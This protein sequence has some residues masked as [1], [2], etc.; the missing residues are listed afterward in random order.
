MRSSSLLL[1][2]LALT[3]AVSCRASEP[4]PTPEA[5]ETALEQAAATA[6]GGDLLLADATTGRI[7][8]H[9]SFAL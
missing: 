9:I 8:S 4:D 2:S 1:T 5:R 7:A 3:A 6:G